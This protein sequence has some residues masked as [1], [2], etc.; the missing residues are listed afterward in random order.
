MGVEAGPAAQILAKGD[1]YVIRADRR[2]VWCEVATPRGL[3]PARGAAAAESMTAYLTQHVLQRR[4]P[5]IGL[6][7]DVR[8]GPSVVGPV[9]LVQLER[10]FAEAELARKPIAAL[11]GDAPAQ[12]QQFGAAAHTY[13]PRFGTVTDSPS[14]ALDWMTSTR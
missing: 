3:A 10:V 9:T 2:V 1:V 4:S 13:A 12:A 7:V 8:R 6:I 5:W 11:I 14:L